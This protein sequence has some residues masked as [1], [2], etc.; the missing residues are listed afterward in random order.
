M[1]FIN[2][3]RLTKDPVGVQSSRTRLLEDLL[4]EYIALSLSASTA[5][6]YNAE[7]YG[8]L[9]RVSYES[10]G[11]ILARIIVEG[12]DLTDDTLISQVRPEYLSSKILYTIFG[13]GEEPLYDTSEELRSQID[14]TLKSIVK[15]ST[16]ESIDLLLSLSA[17]DRS[18]DITLTEETDYIV[19]ALT[20]TYGLTGVATDTATGLELAEGSHRHYAYSKSK[21]LGSTGSPLGYTWGDDLHTHDIIDGVVQPY[22]DSEGVSH[23]H[24]AVYGL[25]ESILKVQENIRRLFEVTRPAHVKLGE[26]S[27]LLAEAIENPVPTLS[28]SL[29]ASYQ[30]DMRYAREG[31]YES[32]FF[33]YTE[34]QNV[35]YTYKSN[36][37]VPSALYLKADREATEGVKHRVLSVSEQLI[38]NGEYTVSSL[39]ELQVSAFFEQN[40]IV[41]PNEIDQLKSLPTVYTITNGVLDFPTEAYPLPDFQDLFWTTVNSGEPL[42][43]TDVNTGVSTCYFVDYVRTPFSADTAEMS[44]GSLRISRQKVVLDKITEKQGL[45]YCSNLS[46]PYRSKPYITYK[47]FSFTYKGETPPNNITLRKKNSF[48]SSNDTLPDDVL[49]SF[50]GLP[51][52]GTD[53]EVYINGT[54]LEDLALETDVVVKAFKVHPT[55]LILRPT[56]FIAGVVDTLTQT[57]KDFLSVGDIVTIKYPYGLSQPKSFGALNQ[58]GFV[59]NAIRKPH[60]PPLANEVGGVD[61]NGIGNSYSPTVLYPTKKITPQA[62]ERTE[63]KSDLLGGFVLNSQATLQDGFTLNSHRISTT[64]PQSGVFAPASGSGIVRGGRVSFADLGF[65]PSNLISVTDAQGGSYVATL[66]RGYVVVPTATEGDELFITA[67][68]TSPYRDSDWFE[69]DRLNEGQVPFVASDAQPYPQA[70]NVDDVMANPQGRPTTSYPN[71]VLT[72][73][74]DR[75][76]TGQVRETVYGNRG[77]LVF[78]EDAF[79]HLELSGGDFNQNLNVLRDR[80]TRQRANDSFQRVD[81]DYMVG[82][83]WGHLY[84]QNFIV[85]GRNGNRVYD[86]SVLNE[87]SILTPSMRQPYE[88][89]QITLIN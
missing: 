80:I 6:N 79:T 64:V 59:L 31:N 84:Q 10:V 42:L 50:E 61:Y 58:E 7:Q 21:G 54:R 71:A 60:I 49:K 26:S 25:T 82:S 66:I 86:Q 36:L 8:S 47:E 70:P 63:I 85:S 68:S 89:V 27:A 43:F 34:G 73:D 38:P 5:S 19:S 88:Q 20:S 13:L 29:G 67:L 35:I 53:F 83:S 18:T 69:G 33:V 46:S 77:E 45:V 11:K 52:I 65:A 1:A 78:F 57:F 15:G 37:S 12:I 44:L 23:T 16:K 2:D 40:F 72:D 51:I 48:I 30:E 87:N 55:V 41:F 62:V 75:E 32:D 74:Q 9:I 28:L 76:V 14:N 24:E 81:A 56:A 17:S 4:A 39:R 22:T 3:P